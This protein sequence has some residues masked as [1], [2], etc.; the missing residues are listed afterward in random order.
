MRIIGI[1][2]GLARVGYGVI[3]TSGGLQRMLDCGIIR[4]DPGR[5]EG[6]RMVEIARDLRLL[7]RTWRPQLAAVEKFFFYRSSTTI[8]VVQARGV[9]MMTLARFKVPVVE[10]P[11]MQIKLALAGSGHAE[12]QEVL[13]AVM[14]ELQLE[15]PPRPDDAADALAVALTGW[16]QR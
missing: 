1:D 12:K 16:F 8:S 6:D 5:S 14:R 11:P 10:F 15:I 13:E 7:I 9:L 2:P 3:D 4:T